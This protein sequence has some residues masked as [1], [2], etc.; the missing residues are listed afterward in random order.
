[1]LNAE[2]PLIIKEIFKNHIIKWKLKYNMPKPMVNMKK[3]FKKIYF[4]LWI[5]CQLLSLYTMNIPSEVRWY[6]SLE[7]QKWKLVTMCL[8]G[9]EPRSSTKEARTFNAE[10]II[11][12]TLMNIFLRG[13]FIYLRVN[14]SENSQII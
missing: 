10:M 13:E 2:L 9:T 14:I 5:S 4:I 3:S 7:L 12:Q 11:A 8:L 1:M 6:R